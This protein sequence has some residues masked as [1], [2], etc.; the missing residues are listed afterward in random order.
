MKRL[1]RIAACLLF[2]GAVA[3]V[4]GCASEDQVTTRP[5]NTPQSW[6]NGLPASMTEGR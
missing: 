2:L 1:V 4:G 5:W 6:E 3:L